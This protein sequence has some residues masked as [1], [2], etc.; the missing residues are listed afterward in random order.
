MAA[1]IRLLGRLDL[2][3]GGH[4]VRFG[5]RR[6]RC[7]LGLLLLE[8]GRSVPVDRLV[9]LLWDGGPAAS[10]RASLRSNVARLRADL[11]H[12]G[13]A[14]SEL[15]LRGGDGGYRADVDPWLV[16]AHRFRILVGRAGRLTEPGARAEVLRDALAMWRGAVLEAD[17]SDRLR[18]RIGAELT[19]LRI[20]ATEQMIDAEFDCGRARQ[21]VGELAVL[22]AEHPQRERLTAQ[23]MLALHQAG[24][25]ADALRVY[26]RFRQRLVDDLGVDP[27]S[28]LRDVHTAILRGVD[29]PGG[30]APRRAVQ[31]PA[32]L[33]AEVSGFVGRRREL[34]TLDDLVATGDRSGESVIVA[35]TGTAGVGKTALAV[36]W[37]HR[38]AARFPDGQLYV[39]LRGFDSGCRLGQAEA[40]RNALDALG[41]TAA[42]IPPTV[43]AQA[44]LYRRLLAGKHVL[45]LVDN[46]RDA[47]HARPLLPGTPTAMA[48]VTSRDQLTALVSGDAAH[49]LTLDVLSLHESRQLLVNRVPALLTTAEPEAADVIIGA[50]ARLPLALVVT[51]ARARQTG[52]SLNSLTTEFASAGRLDALD[53]GDPAGPVRAVFSWSYRTLAPAAARLFRLLGRHPGTDFSVSTAASLAARPLPETHRLLAELTQANLL[54]ERSPGRYHTYA[55]LGAFA[56]EQS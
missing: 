40:V 6:E 8:A 14:P 33:P 7:L 1:D 19:E 28:D 31:V 23:F 2:V 21:L 5:R 30:V 13:V 45:V 44:A 12:G 47:D 39:N 20:T 10:A 4:P 56:A 22:A 35:L 36:H 51:A 15:R 53:A 3:H 49:P 16:D 55:L 54:A 24:R 27:G 41:V 18:E 38:A 26:R 52:F 46:A 25:Q 29:L 9:D 34:A 50:C 37:A 11:R 42:R 48:V 17:A 32:Q 43:D